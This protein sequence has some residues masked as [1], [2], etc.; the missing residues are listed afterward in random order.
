MKPEFE[1]FNYTDDVRRAVLE[2][3]AAE[4]ER[5]LRDLTRGGGTPGDGIPGDGTP[6]SG[7]CPRHTAGCRGLL[8]AKYL[9][10]DPAEHPEPPA[11]EPPPELGSYADPRGPGCT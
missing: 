3:R 1:Y 7:A 6:D 10:F 2:S 8:P 4:L 9:A 5:R 11:D